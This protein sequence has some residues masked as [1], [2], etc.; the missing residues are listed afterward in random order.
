MPC[1]RPLQAYQQAGGSVVFAERGD[2]VRQLML[3]C[4]QCVGCRLERSRQWAVR[5]MHEAS[6]YERNCFV[7][8]TYDSDHV[9]SS[10]VYP[11]FQ[12]FMKRLRQYV[13]RRFT[14]A[15]DRRVRFYMCG[16]YG[17]QFER[18]HFHACLFN[19]DFL[20]K[21]YL[22]R[23]PG[24]SRVYRSADLEKLWMFG[25]SSIGDVN[26]QSAAY[27]ARYVMKKVTGQ[28]A[29]AHYE[30]VDAE[31][32]A[33]V[34]RSPEFNRMSLKPGIGAGWLRKFS[35]DVYPHG[36]VVV[37]GHEANPPRYYDKL[38]KLEDPLAFEDLEYAKFLRGQERHAD[39]TPDRLKAREKV[40]RAKVGLL[41]RSIA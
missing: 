17:E 5:C 29:G 25:F 6:L 1:F 33:I 4:G 10:L 8:L 18:P 22:C 27:V 11:D 21:V 13:R 2:V 41:K 12:N 31:T 14:S 35:S 9:G 32:G 7:T 28:R 37:N 36:R 30:R 16:E 26:F 24:G 23:S 34:R 15:R 39:S 38:W 20:D 3:P 40:A 19:F